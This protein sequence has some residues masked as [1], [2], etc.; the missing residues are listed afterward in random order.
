MKIR[1]RSFIISILL[2][3]AFSSFA[4][5]CISG[6]KYRLP[7]LVDNT[8]N[9][10]TLTSFQVKLVFNSQDLVVSGKMQANGGDLRMRDK[11]G[12]SLAFWIENGTMNQPT[13]VVWVNI[14]TIAANSADTIYAFYGRES[15]S[16]LS[17]GATTFDFFDDFNGSVL[18]AA[19][20][21]D[22][23]GGDITVAGGTLTLSS[24][25]SATNIHIKSATAFSGQVRSEAKVTSVSQGVALL[26][27][28]NANDSGWAMGYEQLVTNN[29]VMRL[30]SLR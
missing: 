22:C 4:Q 11:T 9:G 3:T 18:N 21:D 30:V 25:S 7:V 1:V 24:S 16:S 23:G 15:A 13:T 27:Q 26:G 12:N 14:P 5:P 19:I 8:G 2:A 10:N 20:W 17:N 29:K 6:F 28:I